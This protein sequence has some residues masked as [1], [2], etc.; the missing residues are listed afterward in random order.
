M[1]AFR[2]EDLYFELTR[3]DVALFLTGI[4]LGGY[5]YYHYYYNFL[6]IKSTVFSDITTYIFREIVTSKAPSRL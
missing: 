2:L 1:T 3:E 6:V 5:Y 4:K